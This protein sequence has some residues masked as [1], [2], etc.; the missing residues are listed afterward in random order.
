MT[1]QITRKDVPSTSAMFQRVTTVTD[2]QLAAILAM[3]IQ[4]VG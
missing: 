4:L 1:E 3:N 2:V